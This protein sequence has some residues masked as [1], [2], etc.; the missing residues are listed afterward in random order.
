MISRLARAALAAGALLAAC[1][2]S[3]ASAPS[4]PNL[5]TPPCEA[6]LTTDPDVQRFIDQQ[7]DARAAMFGD[8]QDPG[9][10]F[11]FDRPLNKPGLFDGKTWLDEPITIEIVHAVPADLKN[12]APDLFFL[13]VEAYALV[14]TLAG[15]AGSIPVHA[16]AVSDP[17]GAAPIHA[18]IV[19]DTLTPAQLDA[20][21]ALTRLDAGPRVVDSQTGASKPLSAYDTHADLWAYEGDLATIYAQPASNPPGVDPNCVRAAYKR[22]RIAVNAAH[23]RY[24]ACVALAM[25]E[26]NL[27]MGGCVAGVIWG[28]FGVPLTLTCSAICLASKVALMSYCQYVYSTDIE[29]AR[30]TLIVDLE[31]CGMIIAET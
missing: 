8:A 18:L 5:P 21:A 7:C 20:Y 4:F 9:T 14:G 26:F 24:T 23:D 13:G 17:S 12:H 22:H 31:A 6:P 27:C 11:A 30:R 10:A 19:A 16:L 2:M 1:V 29:A 28:G 25:I 15:P 3:A